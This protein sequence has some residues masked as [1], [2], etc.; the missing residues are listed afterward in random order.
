MLL[1]VRDHVP[2]QRHPSS[3]RPI[4]K[5]SSSNTCSFI[6]QYH[7]P[8]CTPAPETP[9]PAGRYLFLR[10]LGTNPPWSF[11]L[12]QSLLLRGPGPRLEVPFRKCLRFIILPSLVCPALGEVAAFAAATSTM[13]KHARVT[14]SLPN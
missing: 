13:P 10:G 1:P 4:L 3:S 2:Y 7:P 12:A 5:C 11:L 8:T 6:I 14:L 9:A